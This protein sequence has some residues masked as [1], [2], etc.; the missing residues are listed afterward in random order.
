MQKPAVGQTVKLDFD[1]FSTA[2]SHVSSTTI[3]SDAD[4]ASAT[5]TSTSSDPAMSIL[6]AS[7]QSS[8]SAAAASGSAAAA[9]SKISSNNKLRTDVGVGVG[10]GVGGFFAISILLCV[11]WRRH[12]SRPR[13]KIAEV[14]G[15]THSE[16]KYPANPVIPNHSMDLQQHELSNHSNIVEVGGHSHKPFMLDSGQVWEVPGDT[17]ATTTMTTMTATAID[18]QTTGHGSPH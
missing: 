11:I 6:I 13:R 4:I 15:R 17:S 9:V 18:F 5:P 3:R 16:T 8:F 10:V 7:L 1:L 12:R 2:T 14:N